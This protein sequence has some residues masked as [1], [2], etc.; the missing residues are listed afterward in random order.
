M[1]CSSKILNENFKTAQTASP[2]FQNVLVSMRLIVY[3]SGEINPVSDY[4][5]YD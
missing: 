3:V 4:A 1:D 2:V 5:E